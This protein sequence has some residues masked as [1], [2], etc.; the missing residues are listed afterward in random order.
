MAKKIIKN[1]YDNPP[2][3]IDGNLFYGLTLDKEQEEFANA[4][5]NKDND[6][7]FCN[8]KAGT[9]KTTIAVGV[10]N[11]LVQYKMFEK[12]LYVVSPCEEGRLGFLPGDISTKSEVHYEPLYNALQ[13]C[14]IS[15]FTAICTDSL[16]S[17]K[18]EQGYIKPL[19]DVYLRGTNWK[20]SICILEES[21]N[22]EF[23]YLKK[24][25]TRV[26]ENCKV[27]VIG[28][29]G[30]VDLQNPNRSGFQK[31]IEHFRG[32]EH[33]QICELHTN[34]RSWISNWADELE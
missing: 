32:H 9:G 31:Y 21:Q 14:G 17:E 34:H 2:E 22:F 30:Q 13:V 33:C 3:K 10:A 4:I 5:W 20:N 12:I 23:Q 6:I 8:A 15:P 26:G 16:V 29:T 24:T 7:I 28:H 25:L 18:Y 27:I 1:D 19:T 11:M